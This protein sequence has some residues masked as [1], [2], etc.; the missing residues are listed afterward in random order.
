MKNKNIIF[1]VFMV[2]ACA[3]CLFSLVACGSDLSDVEA[4]NLL[5]KG[6]NVDGTF[7]LPKSADGD[8]VEIKMT[9]EYTEDSVKYTEKI[10]YYPNYG[11]AY[12]KTKQ[13]SVS[14]TKTT[15]VILSAEIYANHEAYLSDEAKYNC[16]YYLFKGTFTGEFQ[17][18]DPLYSYEDGT[19]TASAKYEYTQYTSVSQLDALVEEGGDIY[20]RVK[21]IYDPVYTLVTSEL[22]TYSTDIMLP[23]SSDGLGSVNATIAYC[24]SSIVYTLKVS[25][26]D[27]AATFFANKYL[28]VSLSYYN[29]TNKDNGTY[30]WKASKFTLSN[31]N[32]KDP[33]KTS[34]PS[35]EN[36]IEH[37]HVASDPVKENIVEA[38]C[39]IPGHYDEVIYC[40]ECNAEI[41]REEK[42]IAAVGHTPS[43]AHEVDGY[44][45]ITCTVCGAEISKIAIEVPTETPSET[46][47]DESTTE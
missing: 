5:A 21:K 13:V 22:S 20:N 8:T 36:I 3:I 41:S 26:A 19:T 10:D 2:L 7:A 18:G 14:D 1:K 27:L 46:N 6:V 37:V 34:Y 35:E 40:S 43:E 23:Q 17:D 31:Y 33:L 47:S 4:Y 29:T 45:V 24:I 25:K 15:D 16:G 30:V 42:E 28:P 44:N 39:T 32:T 9:H 12:I 11:Y 38:T